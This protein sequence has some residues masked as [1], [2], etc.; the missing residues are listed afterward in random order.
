MGDDTWTTVFPTSF[1]EN[2]TFPYDSFN[3]EDLHSVDEGVIRHLFPALAS[4][5]PPDFLVG[6]FLGVD[7]VGHRVGPE[8]PS[9]RD[10]LAQMN[11]VLARVVDALAALFSADASGRRPLSSVF[12]PNHCRP[13]STPC[14]SPSYSL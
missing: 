4:P 3:V 1:E 7:H 12:L 11:D 13:V 5:T 10:K 2:M 9:M 8:H 14:C 6:H